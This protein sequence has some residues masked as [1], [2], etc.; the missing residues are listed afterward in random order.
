MSEQY[1][2]DALRER[3]QR[4]DEQLKLVHSSLSQ[5]REAVHG[6]EANIFRIE[7]ELVTPIEVDVAAELVEMMKSL[8][9]EKLS[10]LSQEDQL[11]RETVQLIDENAYIMNRLRRE[12]SSK[13]GEDYTLEHILS[14]AMAPS[15][16]DNS[17]VQ[18][19]RMRFPQQVALI[20]TEK[21]AAFAKDIYDRASNLP[22]TGEELRLSRLGYRL[23]DEAFGSHGNMIACFKGSAPYVLK[24]LSSTQYEHLNSLHGSLRDQTILPS[25]IPFELF[26]LDHKRYLI[27]PRLVTSL[28]K[29]P[30]P[31]SISIASELF[32]HIHAALQCLH[33]AKYAHM[34]VS[35][36]N[37]LISE[38]GNF[39]LADLNTIQPFDEYV[40]I[41]TSSLPR[42]FP[43]KHAINIYQHAQSTTCGSVLVSPAV[44][45]WALAMLLLEIVGN[46][47]NNR[48]MF[49]E[50][51]HP[52]MAETLEQI[53]S[54]FPEEV[55]K[56]YRSLT[57]P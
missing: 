15:L 24:S 6:L 39:V 10:I 46:A 37:I 12:L 18:W 40:T 54:L 25:L 51:Q 33:S 28:N 34:E 44:D 29:V 27:M 22:M 2:E 43:G 19:M 32:H 31:M 1:G 49:G 7:T 11:L 41:T 56:V 53:S 20:Y 14:Q 17:I 8:R 35:S 4:N 13:E 38:K 26:A 30:I 16:I 36:G 57:M 3:M 50:D 52:T 55:N 23:C 5:L 42:D 9:T 48:F 47:I 21:N 45:L